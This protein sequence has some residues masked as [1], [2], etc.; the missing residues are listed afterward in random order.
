MNWIKAKDETP[1][2]GADVYVETE[3]GKLG[4]ATYWELTGTQMTN[5]KNL[6][7]RDVVVKWKYN[8][9]T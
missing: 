5:D 8:E 6:G 3:D 1:R 7:L 2:T 9:A 4:V